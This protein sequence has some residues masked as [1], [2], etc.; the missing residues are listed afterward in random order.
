MSLEV[1]KIQFPSTIMLW[2]K[3]QAYTSLFLDLLSII[4]SAE[5]I[6]RF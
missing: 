5:A 4:S 1:F 2:A 3:T 6:T